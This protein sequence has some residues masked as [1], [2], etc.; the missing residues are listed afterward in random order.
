[1]PNQTMEGE[2]EIVND[3]IELIDYINVLCKWKKL[4]LGGT[5]LCIFTAA[6]VTFFLPPAYRVETL[7]E[8]GSIEGK[9]GRPEVIEP[10]EVLLAKIKNGVY[11]ESVRK[12]LGMDE[13]VRL[14][15]KT[16]N[17]KNTSLIKLWMES[18]RKEEAELILSAINELILADHERL[19]GVEKY[20]LDSSIQDLENKITYRKS[21]KAGILKNLELINKNKKQL[22]GQL[23]DIQERIKGLQRGKSKVERKPNPNN[24][25]TLLLFNNEIQENRRY[26]N[27]LQ[28]RL[29]IGVEKEEIDL[30]GGLDEKEST[31]KSLALEKEK[32]E[33][34]LKTYRDTRVVK[35][36]DQS[37]APVRPQKQLVFLLAGFFG[38]FFFISM[39]F[40]LEYLKGTQ[41]RG[42]CIPVQ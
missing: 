25:L 23:K 12:K 31:L 28:D 10:P 14:P 26:Y 3:E 27:Q 8:I 38:L 9:N 32:L 29:D 21:E 7:I 22:Q 18:S 16:E 30:K 42:R 41:E 20:K 35:Q 37:D 11:D 36:V 19:I 15:I 5:L 24:A 13:R 2:E 34:R 17:P 1:L 39:A 4:I 6:V 33:A 40:F